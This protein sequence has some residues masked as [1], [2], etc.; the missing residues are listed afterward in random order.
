MFMEYF[1][2]ANKALTPLSGDINSPEFA[3]SKWAPDLEHA[4]MELLRRCRL[5]VERI[6]AAL[7]GHLLCDTSRGCT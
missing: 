7:K 6:R 5:L 3:L 1:K 4:E 2:C